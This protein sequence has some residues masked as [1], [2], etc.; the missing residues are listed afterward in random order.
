VVIP[1]SESTNAGHRGGLPRKSD[2][3]SV[4]EAEQRGSLSSQELR[5][6]Q[7]MGG[8]LGLRRNLLV[9]Q[10]GLFLRPSSVSR[11]TKVVM[12]SM[13]RVCRTLR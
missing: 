6:N 4:I 13:L 5:V 1:P 9:S 3:V 10:N 12:G 2:E 8:T 7:P 11:Q